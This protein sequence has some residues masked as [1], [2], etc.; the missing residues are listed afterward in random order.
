MRRPGWEG[1]DGRVEFLLGVGFSGR[2]ELGD[3]LDKVGKADVFCVRIRFAVALKEWFQVGSDGVLRGAR[4]LVIVL[5][6]RPDMALRGVSRRH[7]ILIKDFLRDLDTILYLRTRSVT[8]DCLHRSRYTNDGSVKQN[9]DE[10]H[11]SWEQ[12]LP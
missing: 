9:E 8:D 3:I 12:P 4:V 10:Q 2:G 5:S 6:I 11:K 1:D 7:D